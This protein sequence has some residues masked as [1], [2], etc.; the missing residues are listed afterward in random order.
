LL[1]LAVA[2]IVPRV[3]FKTAAARFPSDTEA[4][5]NVIPSG[6]VVL[7]Y[8]FATQLNTEAMSWQAQDEMRFRLIGGYA[9]V[10]NPDSPDY[11]VFNQPPLARPFVQEYLTAGEQI[12]ANP[13]AH[14]DPH[15]AL[16]R[17]ITTYHVTAV[18]FW[19]SGSRADTIKRLFVSDLGAPSRMSHNKQ[20]MVWLTTPGSCHA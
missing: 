10:L 15:R 1:L 16:C 4:V 18:I 17:F 13:P 8:P 3:P 6:S 20:L 11:G 12:Y 14:V 5:L 9:T 7:T 19:N 2:F